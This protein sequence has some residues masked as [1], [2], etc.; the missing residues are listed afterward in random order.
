VT[1]AAALRLLAC[2]LLTT[3]CST[4]APSR[5]RVQSDDGRRREE[6]FVIWFEDGNARP[7]RGT[8]PAVFSVDFELR[9]SEELPRSYGTS[10]AQASGGGESRSERLRVTDTSPNS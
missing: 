3:R 1:R 8:D 4:V 7:A 9:P 2:L 5:P 10:H 6:R